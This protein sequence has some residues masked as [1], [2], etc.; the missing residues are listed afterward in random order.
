[1]GEEQEPLF[2]YYRRSLPLY[3]LF[4]VV[5][6]VEI[7]QW[8]SGVCPTG[9]ACLFALICYT[10]SEVISFLHRFFSSTFHAHG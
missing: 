3:K 2:S 7:R 5:H 10:L 1:M 9:L 6:A 4:D 8:G